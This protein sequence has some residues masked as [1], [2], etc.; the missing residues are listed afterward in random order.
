MSQLD[1]FEATKPR[2]FHFIHFGTFS[3]SSNTSGLLHSFAIKIK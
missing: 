3:V 1:D 2:I